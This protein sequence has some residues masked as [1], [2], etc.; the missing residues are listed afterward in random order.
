MRGKSFILEAQLYTLSGGFTQLT[1]RDIFNRGHCFAGDVYGGS[2]MAMGANGYNWEYGFKPDKNG[3]VM[4]GVT[5]YVRNYKDI[6][7]YYDPSDNSILFNSSGSGR[8]NPSKAIATSG[9]NIPV[10]WEAYIYTI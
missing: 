8:I 3:R 4:V 10:L 9:A 1:S 6:F 7:L 2:F 5:P